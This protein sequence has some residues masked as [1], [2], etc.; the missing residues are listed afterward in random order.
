VEVK[1]GQWLTE[2]LEVETIGGHE[3]WS[4]DEGSG[5]LSMTGWRP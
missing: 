2:I 3:R 4:F 5:F 1:D